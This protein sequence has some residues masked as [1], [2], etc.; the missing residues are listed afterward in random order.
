MPLYA[1]GLRL[2]EMSL[3]RGW[4]PTR[5]LT[6]P[7]ISIG[8]LSTGGSGKT[9]LAI[10]LAKLLSARGFQVDVLS[11]GYGR[12]SAVPLRVDL[13]G[14]ADQFGD[15]PLLIA[16]E[17]GVPVYVAPDRYDAGRLAESEWSTGHVGTLQSGFETG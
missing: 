16:R 7:V 4:E 12:R 1:V 13:Y 10:A 14:S 5:R 2:R 6:Y 17:A 3:Q 15:E 8:N 9:P 11:R